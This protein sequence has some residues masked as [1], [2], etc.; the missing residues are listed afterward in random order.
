MGYLLAVDGGGTKTEFCIHHVETRKEWHYTAGTGNYKTS[1]IDVMLHTLLEGKKWIYDNL[2]ISLEHLD[3]SVFGMSGCD[4]EEDHQIISEVIEKAGL[5]HDKYYLCNDG[6]LAFYAQADVP[7]SVV[8]AGTGSI[9][10]GIDET[11]NSIRA[12]GWGYGYSDIGSGYW[13]GNEALKNTLLYCDG[14]QPYSRLYEEIR[15][16]LGADNFETLPY[17]IT[18]MQEY[19][20]ISKV[21]ACVMK[22]ADL[23]S[24]CAKNILLRGADIL[25]VQVASVFSKMENMGEVLTVVCSGGA[26]RQSSYQKYLEQKLS[27][28]L[29]KQ[30]IRICNQVNSPSY[31]GIRLAMKFIGY[32]T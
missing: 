6:E 11:G 16:F 9:V 28:Y 2:H 25:A 1:G 15:V 23:G 17:Y 8:I 24:E 21:A 14:C 18:R 26:I 3:Y 32:S 5:P 13:I 29:P 4:S 7:G 12:G 20:E 10:I 22:Q 30:K 31:G 27:E 19:P